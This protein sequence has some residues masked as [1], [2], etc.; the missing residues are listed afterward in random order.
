MVNREAERKRLVELLLNVDY[1]LDTD[2]RKAR[3]S[4]EFI[5]DYLLDN[6]IVVPPCKVGDEVYIIKRCRCSKPDCYQQGH[7]D[8]ATTKRTPKSYHTVMEQQ[9]GYKT[10][11]DFNTA[12]RRY[13]PIGTICRSVYKKPFDLKMISELGKTV[14][15]TK[16]EAEKALKGVD[17]K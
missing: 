11:W 9:M 4:A 15:L 17:E 1:A 16:E 3:D 12:E 5:A 6:G 13:V 7:C 14:F 8:K 10:F 2:G